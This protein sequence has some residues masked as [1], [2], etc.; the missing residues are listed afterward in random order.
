MNLRTVVFI[1]TVMVLGLEDK[2]LT[3]EDMEKVNFNS[4]MEIAMKEISA[5]G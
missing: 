3:G 1:D 4:K 2:G 5:M